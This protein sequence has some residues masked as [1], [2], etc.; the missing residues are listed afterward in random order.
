[1]EPAEGE[2]TSS[3]EEDL[4]LPEVRSLFSW[5][6]DFVRFSALQMNPLILLS[7]DR[8][9]ILLCFPMFE[10][11]MIVDGSPWTRVFDCCVVVV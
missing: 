11:V 2:Q 10:L 9:W 8:S 4:L 7:L 5:H 6:L 1:M 3:L